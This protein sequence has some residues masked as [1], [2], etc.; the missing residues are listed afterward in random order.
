MLFRSE[1]ESRVDNH[2]AIALYEA[3]GFRHEALKPRALRFEGVHFDAVQMH[4]L[5]PGV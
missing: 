5:R 1:L 4:L 3:L 2:A